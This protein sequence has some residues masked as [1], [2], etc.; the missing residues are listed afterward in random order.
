MP[1]GATTRRERSSS[2]PSVQETFDAGT[3]LD[4]VRVS[5]CTMYRPATVFLSASPPWA[6]C[7][8]AGAVTDRSSAVWVAYY[9]MQ[10]QKD[11]AA[12]A[13]ATWC[14]RQKAFR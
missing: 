11:G 2:S 7:R 14:S 6:G 13:V 9:A 10:R 4:V 5:T 1:S 3:F 12:P 8:A